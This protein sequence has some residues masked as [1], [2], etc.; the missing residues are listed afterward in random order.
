MPIDLLVDTPAILA[1]QTTYK[2]NSS[3]INEFINWIKF[4]ETFQSFR[5]ILERIYEIFFN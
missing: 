4:L 2:E 5:V 1:I 3:T